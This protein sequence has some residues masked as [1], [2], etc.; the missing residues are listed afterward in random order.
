MASSPQITSASISG[1]QVTLNGSNFPASSDYT[2]TVSFKG[3]EVAI[4]SW[5]GST[6]L[7]ATY[8]SGIP[9]STQA[10]NAAPKLTFTR[11]TDKF[12][13]VAY[14]SNVYLTNAL[15]VAASDS[16][17]GVSVSFAGGLPFTVTKTNLLA[18]LNADSKA[19]YIS[20][21]GNVCQPDQAQSDIDKV[22]CNL[23]PLASVYSYNTYRIVQ[24]GVLTGTW[25][26]SDPSQIPLIYD[27]NWGTEFTDAKANCFMELSFPDG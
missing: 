2:A 13:L 18:T 11:K 5:T 15:T 12:V 27:G 4:N 1:N 19:N 10:E 21:C 22:V 26:A 9:A 24:A 17:S 25:T 6:Q 14:S 3:V 8:T 7:I 20:V 23:P 16:T